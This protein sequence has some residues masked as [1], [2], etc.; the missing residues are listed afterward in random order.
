L[1]VVFAWAALPALAGTSPPPDPWPFWQKAASRPGRTDAV[2]PRVA[3][4]AWSTR[5]DQGDD[6]IMLDCSPVMDGAGRL[7]VGTAEGLTAVESVTGEAL[8]Y[9]PTED[10]VNLSA[11]AWGGRVLFGSADDNFYCL[12]AGTG[13]LLWSVQA[14][15]HPTPSPVVDADGTV[16][17]A[18]Y[19]GVLYARRVDDGR[20]VWTREIGDYI[21]SSPSLDG[22]GRLFIGSCDRN[23]WLAFDTATGD[24]LW[25]FQMNRGAFGTSPV[26]DDRVYVGSSDYNLYCIDAQTG[27]EIWRFYGEKT[28][29]GCVA[30]GVDGT[31]YHAT[32]S[33]GWLFAVD[34]HGHEVWRYRHNEN[35]KSP[36]IVDGSG[37]IYL[38]SYRSPSSGHVHAVKPD[39]TPLWV[40]EMPDYVSASPMLGPDGTLYVVCRDKYLYAFRDWQHAVPHEFL[41]APGDNLDWIPKHGGLDESD[42]EYLVVQSGFPF[43]SSRP[44][45]LETWTTLNSSSLGRL[46]ITVEDHTSVPSYQQLELFN[47]GANRW[48]VIDFGPGSPVD[49]AVAVEDIPNPSAYVNPED[50]R[51]ALR[52]TNWP[53]GFALRP[54]PFATYLDHIEFSVKFR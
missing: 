8:W 54:F 7:F 14:D 25:T 36:P 28:A 5:V 49:E 6:D 44:T 48:E 33:Q 31:V 19:A 20:E 38:C 4:I 32:S 51:I 29:N 39:G 47:F 17:F 42:D 10:H 43:L 21:Y 15:P 26:E 41:T 9:F 18:S 23:Q 13:G 34:A 11:A 12:D 1:A 40:Y 50:N 53:T 2:G 35:V 45:V 27:K 3:V 46:D 16:Y 37:T 24:P 22:Q 30:L 52:I